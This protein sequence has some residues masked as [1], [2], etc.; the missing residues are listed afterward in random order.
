MN[1]DPLATFRDDEDRFA[2]AAVVLLE[3]HAAQVVAGLWLGSE[4]ACVVPVGSTWIDVWEG[5]DI[6]WCAEDIAE[7]SGLPLNVVESK[8]R[9]L[10]RARLIYP[11][12][13]ISRKCGEVL[14]ARVVQHVAG[15]LKAA[16]KR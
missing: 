14:R 1:A 15:A 9:L 8:I 7:A 13:T 4:L 3:D 12:G 10:I 6:G 5:V 11:D 2:P 16:G